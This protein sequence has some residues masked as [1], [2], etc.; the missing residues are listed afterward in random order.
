VKDDNVDLLADDHN[1]MNR[2]KNYF[3]QFFNVQNVIDIRQIEVRTAAPLVDG[4]S[5]LEVEIAI[6]KLKNYKS[7]GSD[8][9]PAY[10]IQAKGEI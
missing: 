3:F 10:L 9:I 1:I 7:S 4:P 6:V 2:W 8:D 5:R